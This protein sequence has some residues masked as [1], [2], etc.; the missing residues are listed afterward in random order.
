MAPT[1][2]V[3]LAAPPALVLPG[4]ETG[5]ELLARMSFSPISDT[6]LLVVS[7]E[8]DTP[9]EAALTIDPEDPLVVA[10]VEAIRGG[11]TLGL[12]DSGR[13]RAAWRGSPPG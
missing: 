5:S 7:A 12:L 13:R 6:Q 9:E 10:V 11:A 2:L 8:G 4:D 1:A 3:S